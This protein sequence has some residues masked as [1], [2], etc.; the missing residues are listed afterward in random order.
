MLVIGQR[1]CTFMSIIMSLFCMTKT[2]AVENLADELWFVSLFSSTTTTRDISHK[3]A[4]NHQ[5]IV[6]TKSDRTL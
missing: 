2:V 5:N 3:S 1:F 4:I 6:R